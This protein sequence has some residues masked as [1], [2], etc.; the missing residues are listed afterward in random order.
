MYRKLFLTLAVLYLLIVSAVPAECAGAKPT[1]YG[2]VLINKSGYMAD[3]HM[4]TTYGQ[5]VHVCTAYPDDKCRKWF[6]R[7]TPTKIVVDYTK[8][9]NEYYG[10]E[11]V[12]SKK[13]SSGKTKV[14]VT[15][16][17]DLT[18]SFEFTN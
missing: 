8:N 10:G 15:L 16:H 17:K 2:L 7:Y 9:I 11:E 18:C 1:A 14:D 3:L 5:R 6:G 4:D 13:W 12:C